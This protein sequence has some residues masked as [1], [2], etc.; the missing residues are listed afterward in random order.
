[1][2]QAEKV[3]EAGYDILCLTDEVDE[4]AIKVL[5]EY[6]KKEFRSGSAGDPGLDNAQKSEASDKD[7]EILK[8]IKE[9]LGDKIKEARL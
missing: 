7:K 6:D 3:K 4:F 1:M 8:F 5:G 9:S 2:P